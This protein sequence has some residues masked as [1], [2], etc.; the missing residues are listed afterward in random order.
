MQGAQRKALDVLNYIGLSDAVL[1]KINRRHVKDKIIAYGGMVLVLLIVF[2]V[3]RN[4][5]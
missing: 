1:K 2:F 4:T 5:R 3:W